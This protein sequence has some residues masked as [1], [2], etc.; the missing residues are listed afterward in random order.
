MLL[1]RRVFKCVS[2]VDDAAGSICLYKVMAFHLPQNTRD[3]MRVRTW[4]ARGPA[5]S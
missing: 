1:N 4:R 5:L 2:G 3:E